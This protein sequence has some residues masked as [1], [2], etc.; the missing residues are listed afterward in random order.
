MI[1]RMAVHVYLQQGTTRIREF[2]DPAG[3]IFDEAGDLDALLPPADADAFPIL[4]HVDPHHDAELDPAVMPDLIDEIDR[5][6][7]GRHPARELRGLERFRTL[8]TLCARTEHTKLVVTH[9]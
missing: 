1:G 3:G 4:A 7:P 8:A 5:L 6:L 9:S 2:A